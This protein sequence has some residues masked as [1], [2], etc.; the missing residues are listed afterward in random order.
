[1][2]RVYEAYEFLRGYRRMVMILILEAQ[3]ESAPQLEV[4]R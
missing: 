3:F 1:M 2:S 4:L